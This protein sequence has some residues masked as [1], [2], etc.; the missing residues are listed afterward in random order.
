MD[1]FYR[2]CTLH[3]TVLQL[4]KVLSQPEY[5]DVIGW[6][7]DGKSFTIVKPKAFVADI[8]PGQFKEAK[9]SSFTRKL[10][11]WGFQRHLRGDEAGAFFHKLFQRGRLDLVE[12]MTCYKADQGKVP[13]SSG[14]SLRP[15]SLRDPVMARQGHQM[16]RNVPMPPQQHTL[17]IPDQFRQPMHT[18]SQRVGGGNGV[19]EGSVDRLNAAIELE[20]NRRLKERIAAATLSRQALALMQQQQLP[21]MNSDMN[22]EGSSGN[23]N[24]MSSLGINLLGK[25]VHIGFNINDST[26]MMDR[27]T[28]R[29]PFSATGTGQDSLGLSAS[30]MQQQQHAQQQWQ[31]QQQQ[32]QLQQLQQQQAQQ[33]QQFQQQGIWG[34]QPFS[35]ENNQGM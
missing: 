20:V 27:A 3:F 19:G 28:N 9:Y 8:L 31:L 18:P 14:V 10:H 1:E 33:Q 11:R 12:K 5:A 4:M 29:T 22:F 17:T 23:N 35:F 6:L 25:D 21:G 32:L 7:P 13:L 16:N 24:N 15:A 34:G 2:L 26:T 30:A